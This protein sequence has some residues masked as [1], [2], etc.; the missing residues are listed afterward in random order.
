MALVTPTLT[1][2][3]VTTGPK[4]KPTNSDIA[5]FGNQQELFRIKPYFQKEVHAGT[6]G[7]PAMQRFMLTA[8]PN[9]WFSAHMHVKY[10]ALYPHP[11]NVFTHFLSLDKCLGSRSCIQLLQ[12]EGEESL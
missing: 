11:N 1:L 8:Q 3:S 5:L 6:L 2:P 4:V 9:Y 10:P 12:F 7:S